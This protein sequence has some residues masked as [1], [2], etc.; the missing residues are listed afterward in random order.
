MSE[1]DMQARPEGMV[2][3][4]TKPKG[5]GLAR[6]KS[7]ATPTIA[8]VATK[9]GLL[10][11]D[12]I[13]N[14]GDYVRLHP[15]EAEYWSDELCFVRVPTQG[16][17]ND[18]LHLIDEALAMEHLE[19]KQIL[20]FRLA[21][22][23]KPGDR[24]FLAHVPTQNLDNTWNASHIEAC[25]EA[26]HRWVQALSRRSEGVDGYRIKYTRDHDAFPAPQWPPESLDDLIM[27]TFKDHMIANDDHPGLLRLIGAKLVP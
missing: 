24:F 9:V 21:L 19:A 16:A 12:S 27:A 23:A 15:N 14:A 6:F 8:G 11:H 4:I 20:R 7:K 13:A 22:A 10:S 18:V 26:K 17:K 5:E 1:A 25:E 2:I 3:P